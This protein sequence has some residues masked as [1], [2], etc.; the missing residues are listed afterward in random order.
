MNI[1]DELQ[2]NA[3][4]SKQLIR[5]AAT[6]REKR[7][8]ALL[9][10]GK[11]VLTV[12]FCFCFV[13][14]F[15][16][17]FGSDNSVP[18]VVVLLCILT[19]RFTDFGIRVPHAVGALAAIF[20]V[21]AFLPRLANAVPSGLAFFVHLTAVFVLVLLGCHNVILFNQAVLV[22]GYLLL[23]GY[24]VTG[25][26]YARRLLALAVGFVLTSLVYVRSHR[27]RTYK[28]GF[29]DLLKEFN[30]HSARGRWQVSMALGVSGALLLAALLGL[31]RTMWAGIACMSVIVPFRSDVKRRVRGRI[32][33]NLLG[34][35]LFLLLYGVLPASLRP[36]LGIIGGIGV[37]FSA[38]Y[39]WQAVFNSLGAMAIAVPLLG[40]P[41]AV[42]F[43]IFNN[44]FG[45]L[46]GMAFEKVYSL[47]LR[48]I[49]HHGRLAG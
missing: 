28:R 9:Y 2:L 16:L 40:V 23:F 8:H 26:S 6:P 21:F 22:L 18:G 37:G 1:Y 29:A 14:L 17:L 47:V 30:L 15:S 43:R 25:A 7:R 5:S 12:A 33:G 20:A 49:P 45:A 48:A 24:D 19:F 27:R 31:P 34:G 39:G 11:V 41:G 38:T 44:V 35:A 3:G 36:Y 10:V 46:Y 42:F 4:G 32:P 13:T